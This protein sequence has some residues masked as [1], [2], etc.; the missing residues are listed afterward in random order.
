MS[1]VQFDP[2]ITPD[3]QLDWRRPSNKDAD[4]FADLLKRHVEADQRPRAPKKREP[5]DEYSY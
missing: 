2:K 3:F 1:T 4:P 5:R